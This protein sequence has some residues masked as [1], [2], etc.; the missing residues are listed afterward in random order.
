MAIEGMKE[1]RIKLNKIKKID[2]AMTAALNREGIKLAS[3]IRKNVQTGSRT[4]QAY[5][6]PGGKIHIASAPGE[7]PKSDTGILVSSISSKK[8]RNTIIVGVQRF[9]P[10]AAY[11]N[12]LEFGGKDKKGRYIAPRPFVFRTYKQN[13]AKIVRNASA[14]FKKRITQI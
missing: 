2:N 6:R 11:A 4:G 14:F 12:R 5:V 3:Q 7:M 1:L 10:G 8:S 9:T 13:K